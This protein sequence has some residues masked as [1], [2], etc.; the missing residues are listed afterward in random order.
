MPH[1][2]IFRSAET[3][4]SKTKDHTFAYREI[5]DTSLYNRL[6]NATLSL[7]PDASHGGIFQYHEEFVSQAL[8]FLAN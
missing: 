4:Y 5:G 3:K 7:F 2:D 6:P 1:V 8:E